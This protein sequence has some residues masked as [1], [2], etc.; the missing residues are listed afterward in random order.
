MDAEL[1][2]LVDQYKAAQ[3]PPTL[4]ERMAAV[5]NVAEELMS[6]DSII[7]LDA[8]ENLVRDVQQIDEEM[9]KIVSRIVRDADAGYFDS[10]PEPVR[11]VNSCPDKPA[12]LHGFKVPM[13]GAVKPDDSSHDPAVQKI[14]DKIKSSPPPT[15]V[16]EQIKAAFITKP[17]MFFSPIHRP[18]TWIIPKGPIDEVAAYERLRSIYRVNDEDRII[19]ECAREIK[20][21]IVAQ[22]KSE[23]LKAEDV[24][25]FAPLKERP[26]TED[27]IADLQAELAAV[28]HDPNLTITTQHITVHNTW[29]SS[30][31][32]TAGDRFTVP[33]SFEDA[34]DEAYDRL[35]QSE[36][37]E[38]E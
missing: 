11:G 32:N 9:E 10:Q 7:P 27:E 12:N 24:A 37:E 26:A 18:H 6:S 36:K 17:P 13:Y 8:V 19:A 30:E 35:K 16:T 4:V 5:Q 29:G 14:V 28:A 20:R 15:S 3:S 31:P 38:V 33:Y 25:V 34:V 21:E 1:Q 23:I 2:K 22:V